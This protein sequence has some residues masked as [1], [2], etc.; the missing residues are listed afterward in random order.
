MSNEFITI[1]IQIEL[2]IYS[3]RTNNLINKFLVIIKLL[4]S[5]EG[6]KHFYH[7]IRYLNIFEIN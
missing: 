2:Q 4:K 5:L 6:W 7:F 1:L 3:K